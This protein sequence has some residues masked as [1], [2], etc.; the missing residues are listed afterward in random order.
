MD[1]LNYFYQFRESSPNENKLTRAFLVVLSHIPLA[2]EVFLDLVRESMDE[3]GKRIEQ[4]NITQ[5]QK[6]Y[7]FDTQVSSPIDDSHKG[8]M[9]VS[10]LLTDKPWSCQENA[11][12]RGPGI[13]DGII[14]APPDWTLV[15]ENKPD[16]KNIDPCQIVPE[17]LRVLEGKD[18]DIEVYPKLV[19]VM[20]GEFIDRFIR[21]KN[22]GWITYSEDLLFRD[23]LYF[24]HEIYPGLGPFSSFSV[25]KSQITRQKRCDTII[26]KLAPENDGH[27]PTVRYDGSGLILEYKNDDPVRKVFLAASPEKNGLWEMTLAIY[28]ADTIGQARSFYSQVQKDDFLKLEDS[29]WVIYPTFHLSYQGSH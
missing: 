14:S 8:S 13:Y 12:P 16:A 19:Q 28:P 1:K 21:I 11:E 20:W 22:L 27:I 23:F 5:N 7:Y 15:I 10:V 2:L 18:P 26:R 17:R 24:I 25:A 3:N 9:L 29:G 4:F 6:G